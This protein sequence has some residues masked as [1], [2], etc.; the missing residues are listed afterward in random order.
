[1]A[2]LQLSY[3]LIENIEVIK[4]QNNT[5][6]NSNSLFCFFSQHLPKDIEIVDLCAPDNFYKFVGCSKDSID[7]YT[8]LIVAKLEPE[9]VEDE[10][11][12]EKFF[13]YLVD[14]K[15]FGLIGLPACKIFKAFYLLPLSKEEEPPVYMPIA[16]R[17]NLEKAPRE[18]NHLLGLLVRIPPREEGEI[19]E[20]EGTP[21]SK[22]VNQPSQSQLLSPVSPGS[23]LDPSSSELPP[24][25]HKQT[26]SSKD[27]SKIF[28]PLARITLPANRYDSFIGRSAETIPFLTDEVDDVQSKAGPS[29]T[30]GSKKKLKILDDSLDQISSSENELEYS[31]QESSNRK[32]SRSRSSSIDSKPKV[33]EPTQNKVRAASTSSFFATSHDKPKSS[34]TLSTKIERVSPEKS[35]SVPVSK[36]DV[37]PREFKK[38]KIELID[39]SDS[40]NSDPDSDF[41]PRKPNTEMSGTFFTS[42]GC[43]EFKYNIISSKISKQKDIKKVR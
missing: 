6:S 13:Q 12:Y 18:D 28:G 16:S 8:D 4:D 7:V 20:R 3:Y 2:G 35:K 1:M 38:D 40:S 14:E 34:S 27:S 21:T 15:K 19:S 30:E 23:I 10:E 42:A 11:N 5:D 39:V 31:T 24:M 17:I 41:F 25:S 26:T 29:N 22:Q 33:S 43:F 36:Q 32:R 37:E 9:D